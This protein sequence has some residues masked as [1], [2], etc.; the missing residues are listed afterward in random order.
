[1]KD[2]KGSVCEIRYSD[3][4]ALANGQVSSVVRFKPPEF[5]KVVA[6]AIVAHSKDGDRNG[7]HTAVKDLADLV[8]E[9]REFCRELWQG[10]KQVYLLQRP[11]QNP[12]GSGQ[13]REGIEGRI[14]QKLAA[15]CRL[16]IDARAE[17]EI[18]HRKYT[19]DETMTLDPTSDIPRANFWTSED[20]YAWDWVELARAITRGKG[21]MRSK[22]MFTRVDIRANVQHPLGK[23]LQA[24][25]VEQ[26]K[27]KR[28]VRP[29]TID[30]LDRLAKVL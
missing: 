22:Q 24:L 7:L 21:V 18:F 15:T 1:M 10:E 2:L 11:G 25:Q 26:S 3:F 27:L 17:H 9:A 4:E 30:E 13:A 14:A 5:V 19:N 28:G 16:G 20:G 23:G 12:R 6:E 8:Q 29:Q